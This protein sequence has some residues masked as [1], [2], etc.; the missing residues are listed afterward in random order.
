MHTV[1]HDRLL[2]CD[3]LCRFCSYNRVCLL[4]AVLLVILAILSLISLQR[5]LPMTF[6]M[7]APW[8]F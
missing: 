2:Q 1:F 4:D 5:Q 3:T 6:T 8:L 7:K